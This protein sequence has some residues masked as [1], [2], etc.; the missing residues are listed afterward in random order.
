MNI[1]LVYPNSKPPARATS[2]S[3]GYDVF[4][5]EDAIIYPGEQRKIS[6][7]FRMEGPE[8][9]GTF[10]IPRSGKGS[11][12]YHLANVIGL[13]DWDYRGIA[14][15]N[16][17]NAGKDPINIRRGEAIFQMVIVP[18]WTPDL[19]IVESLSETAR[20]EGGFGSTGK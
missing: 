3:A 5:D 15:A 4:A 16:T 6:L 1:Q 9:H 18:V 11:A 8:Q 12:G 2:G 7:G 14:I 10:L 13:L 20:G 17:Y 19:R